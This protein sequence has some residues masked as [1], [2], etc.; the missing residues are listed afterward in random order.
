MISCATVEEYVLARDS[1]LE[2]NEPLDGAKY[3]LL[4]VVVV[5]VCQYLR[6]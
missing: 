6:I 2:R 1:S 5:R 4:Y 3:S